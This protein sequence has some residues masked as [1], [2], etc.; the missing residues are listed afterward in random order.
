VLKLFKVCELMGYEWANRMQHINFGMVQ[1]MSTRKG[2][3]VFLDQILNESKDVMH[4][5][6][7]K[8]E[9]KYKAVEDPEMTSDKLGI[10]AVKIQDMSAKRVGNYKFE[11]SRMTSFEG[12]TG[13][14]C[15]FLRPMNL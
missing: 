9:A 1:G 4:E 3:A 14:Y 12:D 8:N 10:T 7:K 6:M 13:V 2:T 15:G 5:Q 11:W